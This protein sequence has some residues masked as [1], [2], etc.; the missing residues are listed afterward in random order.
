MATTDTEK[1]EVLYK[2]FASVFP[3]SQASHVLCVPEP[4]DS[5][6]EEQN[7]SYCKQRLGKVDSVLVW[8]LRIKTE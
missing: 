5:G 3:G 8:L 7:P 2:F 1:A 4:P 6:R